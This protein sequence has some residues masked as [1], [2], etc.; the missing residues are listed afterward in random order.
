MYRKWILL[1]D[2]DT[3]QSAV[4]DIT[5]FCELVYGAPAV[6]TSATRSEVAYSARIPLSTTA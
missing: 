5:V 6:V 4:A 1:V 3:P 2:A